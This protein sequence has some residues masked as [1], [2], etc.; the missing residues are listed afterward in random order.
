MP[1]PVESTS[2]P[3]ARLLPPG[4]TGSRLLPSAAALKPATTAGASFIISNRVDPDAQWA[5]YINPLPGG[6]LNWFLSTV[7]ANDPTRDDY[8]QQGSSSTTAPDSFSS[9]ITAALTSQTGPNPQLT[10]FIHGLGNL[11]SAGRWWTPHQRLGRPCREV[12]AIDGEVPQIFRT[13]DPIGFSPERT[14]SSAG[15]TEALHSGVQGAGRQES[16]RLLAA[17]DDCRGGAGTQYQRYHARVLGEGVP[18]E[19]SG[20]AP[21]RPICPTTSGVLAENLIRAG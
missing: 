4:W 21:G 17:A 6:Q 14:G 5:H 3:R 13:G 11:F 8:V 2:S 20:T 19:T 7:Q 12:P 15:E 9:A 10:V 18:E 16:G 1:S